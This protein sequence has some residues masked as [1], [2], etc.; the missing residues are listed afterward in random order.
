[1]SGESR[2][3]ILAMFNAGLHAYG[4]LDRGADLFRRVRPSSRAEGGS[5]ENDAAWAA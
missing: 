4:V 1:L 2:R 3:N 5:V